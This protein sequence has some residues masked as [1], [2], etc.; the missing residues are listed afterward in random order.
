M[1]LRIQAGARKTLS[2]RMRGWC[3][4]LWGN[5][6]LS[7]LCWESVWAVAAVS[8]FSFLELRSNEVMAENGEELEAKI[9]AAVQKALAAE[10]EKVKTLDTQGTGSSIKPDLLSGDPSCGGS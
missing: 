9:A 4:L 2:L 6:M 3:E 10:R 7:A 8:F 5:C 1:E